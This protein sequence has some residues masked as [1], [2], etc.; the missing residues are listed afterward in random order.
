MKNK[1]KKDRNY[2]K[3]EVKKHENLKD[4]TLYSSFM[5]PGWKHRHGN[6]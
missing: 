4:I 3:P 6:E 2:S 5:P 1:E